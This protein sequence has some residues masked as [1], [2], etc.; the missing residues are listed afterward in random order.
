MARANDTNP[1]AKANSNFAGRRRY[2]TFQMPRK[3]NKR[4]LGSFR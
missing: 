2:Q 1:A 4:H 3:L